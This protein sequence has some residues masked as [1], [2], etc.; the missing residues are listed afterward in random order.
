MHRQARRR[1]IRQVG[2]LDPQ[3]DGRIGSQDADLA[4][5]DALGEPHHAPGVRLVQEKQREPDAREEHEEPRREPEDGDRE[6]AG[7]DEKCSTDDATTAQDA[8]HVDRQPGAIARPLPIVALDLAAQV[9]EHKRAR[10]DDQ[11]A[12]EAKPVA[13]APADDRAR[14]EVQQRED[15]DLL[16]VRRASARREADDLE[17]GGELDRESSTFA[18]VNKPDDLHG[19]EREGRD[20]VEKRRSA[21]LPLP[22]FGD[23]ERESEADDDDAARPSGRARR[24]SPARGCRAPRGRR[25][26]AGGRGRTSSACARCAGRRGLRGVAGLAAPRPRGV[27]GAACTAVVRRERWRAGWLGARCIDGFDEREEA[28][29][30]VG[31]HAAVG[32]DALAGGRDDAS[33]RRRA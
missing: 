8:R 10:G 14:D 16:V 15:D 2:D 7:R 9:A 26:S 32:A 20:G 30:P 31:A 11:K 6:Q 19:E 1:R 22:A 21:G 25:S 17:A 27:S 18:P 33:R 3:R 29:E 13:E 28:Q 5:I 12:E 23:R 4:E 24:W